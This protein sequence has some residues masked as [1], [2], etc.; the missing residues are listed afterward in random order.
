MTVKKPKHFGR[1]LIEKGIITQEDLQEALLAQK[2]LKLRLGEIIVRK[3]LA[4]EEDIISALSEH[5]NIPYQMTIQFEDPK[6]LFSQIPIHFLKNNKLAPFRMEKSTIFVALYDALNIR[7][8]DDLKMLFPEYSFEPVMTTENEIQRLIQ[9]H[10]D[11]MNAETTGDFIEDLEDADLEILSSQAAEAEDILDMAN[12]APIIRL[13]NMVL[14]Q[15]VNDRSSDIHIEPYEKDLVVRFRIDGILYEMFTPPKK[16]QGAIIS[17]IKIMANLNIAENRLPQDGRIQIK[18]GGKDI[19]IRVSIFP[20][21]YGERVVLRLLNKTDME[22]NL[23][24][25]GFEQKI[26]ENF[27][28]QIK[29]SHGIILVTGPTGSGKTTT[30]YCVLSQLNK[31]QVNILT[32]EDPIEYQIKGIGQMQ[33]KSKID[34]TFANGLRSILR[35]DPDII[36]VGEIRDVETAEIAVQSALTGHLVLSTLHTNDAASGITRLIDMGIEPFLIS[37]SVNAFLAQRLVRVICPHCRETYKPT[38][39]M[40]ADLGLKPSQLK[41]GK[42]SRGKGCEKCLNTGFLGRT[43]IYELLPVTTEIRKLIMEHADSGVIKEAAVKNGM[44]TLFQD[45]LQKAINGETTVEEILRVS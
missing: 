36:M 12:E 6:N 4:T 41:G 15:A 5:Y 2:T 13:V 9:S 22:F 11:T 25:L 24:A 27:N 31:P 10:Y 3:G 14:K 30:L 7:P 33:V 42:L 18:I 1:I 43:G 17:R 29:K 38:Q 40:L 35:Q 19:D 32:V 37:S 39:K 45:G 20:T 34:L 21:Y 44:I 28:A 16:F 23:D 26:L 8:L